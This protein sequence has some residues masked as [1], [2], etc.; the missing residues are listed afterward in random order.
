MSGQCM[1]KA[2]DVA[3]ILNV[4]DTTLLY[5]RQKGIFV[6]EYRTST[7]RYYYSEAQIADF[8]KELRENAQASR[9]Q[10]GVE[11]IGEV[12]VISSNA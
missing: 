12:A 11:S 10:A 1:L 6:P 9:V 8:L 5:W 2:K 7:G 3:E 4:P